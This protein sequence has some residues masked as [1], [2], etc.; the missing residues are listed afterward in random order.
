MSGA[1]PSQ[2]QPSESANSEFVFRSD[3]RAPRALMFSA[4]TD[5]EE[6]A[7]WWR[8][9]GF[10]NTVCELDP[11]SGGRLRIE[12]HGPDGTLYPMVGV[13]EVVESDRVVFTCLALDEQGAPLF[14]IESAVTFVERASGGTT[15]TV[16]TRVRRVSRGAAIHLVGMEAGFRQSLERLADHLAQ[17]GH[18]APA[19]S[20]RS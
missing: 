1:Q 6:M 19:A 15:Q 11:R 4:W 16:R 12:M 13:Y 9:H 14:E 3:Y 20:V 2:G 5:P 17:G 18:V 7:E 10:R 8:P